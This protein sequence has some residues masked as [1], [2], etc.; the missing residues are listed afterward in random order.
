MKKNKYLHFAPDSVYTQD[1]IHKINK[2]YHEKEHC[3]FVY[4]YDF[5]KKRAYQDN[6]IFIIQNNSLKNLFKIIVKSVNKIYLRNGFVYLHQKDV[7]HMQVRYGI[8]QTM[9][10]HCKN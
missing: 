5:G 10:K 6:N 2:L 3:F 8:L 1:Y 4:S 9:R 7:L